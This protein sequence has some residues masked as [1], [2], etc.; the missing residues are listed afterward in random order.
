MVLAAAA[1]A[2]YFVG[3]ARR[4]FGKHARELTRSKDSLDPSKAKLLRVLRLERLR[5]GSL[6]LAFPAFLPFLLAIWLRA[7]EWLIWILLAIPVISLLVGIAASLVIEIRG[8]FPR[9]QV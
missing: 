6:A 1:A 7:P 8:G 4:V 2:W 3:N 9:D 5:L